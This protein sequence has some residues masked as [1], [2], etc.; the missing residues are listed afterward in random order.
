MSV[1]VKESEELV[2]ELG[3]L[4]LTGEPSVVFHIVVHQVDSL[5][6]EER[7]ELGVLVDDVA[8]MDFVDLGVEGLV[9][10][11]GPEEHPGQ[12]G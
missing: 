10:D 6:F 1:V 12:D 3:E 9:S 5:G 2:L 8:Q 4:L 11:S 7:A